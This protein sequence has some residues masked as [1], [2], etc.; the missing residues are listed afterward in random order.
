[1]NE[2]YVLV[3]ETQIDTD[4]MCFS[5]LELAKTRFC[6]LRDNYLNETTQQDYYVIEDD[7][8]SVLPSFCAYPDGFYDNEHFT[9]TI[10]QRN[11]DE[12]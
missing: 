11:L 8:D 10:F 3:L 2:I 5:A 12:V 9:I 1:M 7:S 4:V 6:E